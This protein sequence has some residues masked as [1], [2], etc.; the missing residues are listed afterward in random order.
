ME[1]KLKKE[2]S[3]SVSGKHAY[4]ENAFYVSKEKVTEVEP[5]KKTNVS[6]LYKNG[7]AFIIQPK[8]QPKAEVIVRVS[9]VRNLRGKVKGYIEV[10]DAE[11]QIVLRTKYSKLKIR[12]CYGNTEYAWAIKSVASFLNLP[13]KRH[14]FRT[15]VQNSF[16]GN[17]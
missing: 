2:R 9:L 1:L 3:K 7:E 12:R 14:N 17:S 8:M 10:F 5:L 6:P 15:G 16:T 13:V 11:G 4:F